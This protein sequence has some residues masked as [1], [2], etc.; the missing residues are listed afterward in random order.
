M[1]VMDDSRWIAVAFVIPMAQGMLYLLHALILD[2]TQR[3]PVKGGEYV[4]ETVEVWPYYTYADNPAKRW[5]AWV[6]FTFAQPAV[7]ALVVLLLFVAHGWA[8]GIAFTAAYWGRAGKMGV[9]YGGR[10]SGS[11]KHDIPYALA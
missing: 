2:V 5:R 6:V 4:S 9:V 11:N 8:N 7:V 10:R 1:V 3:R